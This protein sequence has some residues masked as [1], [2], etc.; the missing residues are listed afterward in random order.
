MR[1]VNMIK[2][3]ATQEVFMISYF[4]KKAIDK[5]HEIKNRKSKMRKLQLDRSRN[6]PQPSRRKGANLPD[7]KH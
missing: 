2:I 6:N 1:L 3:I 4:M 5:S 7:I